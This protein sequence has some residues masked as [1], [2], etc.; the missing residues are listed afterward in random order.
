VDFL[1]EFGRPAD[2]VT[3]R[4]LRLALGRILGREVDLVR[5][6]YLKWYVRPQALA[7]AVPV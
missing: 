5:E 1:V 3:A 6:E 4:E 2:L 7:D